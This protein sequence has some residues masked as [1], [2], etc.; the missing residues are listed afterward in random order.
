MATELQE[1]ILKAFDVLYSNRIRELK[2]DETVEVKI[3]QKIDDIKYKVEYNGG[4]T[5]A[6]DSQRIGPFSVDDAAMERAESGV[7]RFKER[8]SFMKNRKD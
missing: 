1:S 2:L 3:I 7:G 6:Y 8:N 4:I 5:V